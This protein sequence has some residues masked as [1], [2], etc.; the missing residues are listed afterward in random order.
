MEE[1]RNEVDKNW[2]LLKL[3]KETTKQLQLTPDGIPD[4]INASRSIKSV[5]GSLTTVVQGLRELRN[6]YGSGHGKKANFK[7]LTTRHAK[8]SV[9]AASTL[10]I[11]LLETHKFRA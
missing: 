5:L 7:G 1:R 4:T 11:F 8:L 9:G 6:Q 3:L 10:A 2:D